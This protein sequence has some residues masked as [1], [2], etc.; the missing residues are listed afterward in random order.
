MLEGV[1]RNCHPCTYLVALSPNTIVLVIYLTLDQN[2]FPIP[3][4]PWV[5]LF[6]CTTEPVGQYRHSINPHLLNA[7]KAL[8]RRHWKQFTVPTFQQWFQ[9]V[10]QTCHME[11]LTLEHRDLANI[12]HKIWTCWF[13]FS[14]AS[15]EIMSSNTRLIPMVLYFVFYHIFYFMYTL[16]HI[17]Y[18]R[19]NNPYV[20]NL[21]HPNS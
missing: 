21:E 3:N 15:S 12:A 2:N 8:I 7:A 10:D 19:S 20:D 17:V 14:S 18:F 6:H 11:D 5:V 13:T 9:E 16:Y 4:D 1:W